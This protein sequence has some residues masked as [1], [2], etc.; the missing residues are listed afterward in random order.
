MRGNESRREFSLIELLVVIAIIAILASLLLPALQQVRE[1]G[2]SIS[3]LNVLGQIG[4]AAGMYMMDNRDYIV[5]YGI[6]SGKGGNSMWY[7]AS[8]SYSSGKC[9]GSLANYLNARTKNGILGGYN[10]AGVKTNIHCPSFSLVKTG[11]QN[12]GYGYNWNLTN[13]NAV[14]KIN[15]IKMPSRSLHIGESKVL[16]PIIM[17][18][19]DDVAYPSRF[20][21]N[22][23]SNLLFFDQHVAWMARRQQPN[24]DTR[25]DAR[26]STFWDP[27]NFT[28]NNW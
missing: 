20:S 21:H 12:Y 3:C 2:K 24:S 5:P 6:F 15:A 13:V 7:D 10:Q 17:Y 14:V 19:P 9:V 11:I 25:N 23:G 16:M 4:R 8:N 18:K 22:N 1:K 27:I 26:D 28:H